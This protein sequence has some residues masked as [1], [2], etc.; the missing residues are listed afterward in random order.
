MNNEQRIS[1]C[2]MSKQVTSIFNIDCSRVRRKNDF[3]HSAK[4]PADAKSAKVG[5]QVGGRAI[6]SAEGASP[7]H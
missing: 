6:F 2:R 4:E 7:P 1:N 5:G 3:R